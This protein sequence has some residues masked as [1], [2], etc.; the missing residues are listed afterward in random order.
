MECFWQLLREG[1][2]DLDDVGEKVGI[3]ERDLVG[4]WEIVGNLREEMERLKMRFD[5][6]GTG[7]PLDRDGFRSGRYGSRRAG[8]M[9][10]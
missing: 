10:F 3:L 6:E 5:D 9:R 7:E 8:E 4:F 2:R 1:L